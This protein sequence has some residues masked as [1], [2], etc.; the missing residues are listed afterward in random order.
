MSVNAMI[1]RMGQTLGPLFAGALLHL[2]ILPGAYSGAYYGSA[3][4]AVATLGIISTVVK[5]EG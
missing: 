3:V 5:S 1:L 2:R 4:L